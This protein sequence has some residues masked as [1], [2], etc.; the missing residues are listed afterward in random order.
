[1]S[2]LRVLIAD[3]HAIVRAGVRS[4]LEGEPDIEVVG[5]AASG[6]EAVEKAAQLQPHLVLM[7]IAMP[8]MGGIEA[9][10]QLKKDLPHVRVL[11]LTMHDDEEFFFAVL[12]AGASGY[13]LKHSEPQQLLYAIRSVGDDQTFLSPTVAR[14]LLDGYVSVA[15]DQENEKYGTLSP[16]E[17]EVLQLVAGGQTNREI[18]ESLFLS[19]RT[20]EKHRQAAMR[21]LDLSSPGDVMKYAIRRGLVDLNGKLA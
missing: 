14:A 10:G 12:R 5:E 9:T 21:K 19:I 16:R 11:V 3:D 8:G 13:I 7:D 20:V 2:Q 6:A 1:M 18:A 4:L 15:S 17:R